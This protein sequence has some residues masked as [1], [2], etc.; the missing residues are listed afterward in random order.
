MI[1]VRLAAYTASHLN[2]KLF[3]GK[4]VSCRVVSVTNRDR[5]LPSDQIRSDL[6]I[7]KFQNGS[8]RES[9]PEP[10]AQRSRRLCHVVKN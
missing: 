10:H 6:E 4:V 3:V 5:T 2:A 1:T 8:C 7:I 9:N